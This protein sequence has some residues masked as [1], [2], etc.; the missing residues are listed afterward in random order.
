M[1]DIRALRLILCAIG[2]GACGREAAA[3]ADSGTSETEL[4]GETSA[5][6]DVAAAIDA[7]LDVET[8][9]EVARDVESDGQIAADPDG[10][11]EADVRADGAEV[12]VDL[13]ACRVVKSDRVPLPEASGAALIDAEGTRILLVADSG[14]EGQA[15]VIDLVAGRSSATRLPLGAGAGDDVEGLERAPDGRIFGLTSAGFLRAWRPDGDAFS[16]V[17]GPVAVSADPAWVCDP[18]GVNCAANFEG[19]CLHPA[20]EA[21]ECAGWAAAKATG[22]LVCLVVEGEGYRLDPSRRVAVT[23]PDRLSGCAFEPV[24]PF[25]L[26]AAGNL[27]SASAIWEIDAD[28]TAIELAERGAGNQE[29]ILLLSGGRLHSLGDAQDFLESESPR[30]I[31]ECV[32]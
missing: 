9:A 16:L 29:A 20:P 6:D 10:E 5:A 21:G 19:L 31:M 18:F 24:S 3:P 14:N 12:V 22:E 30:I 25:R 7:G 11:A 4:P 17:L 26:V 27:V 2:L 1:V 15:L 32:R 23:D 13:G 28:G 8:V